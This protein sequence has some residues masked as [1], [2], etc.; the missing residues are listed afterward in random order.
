MIV[1]LLTLLYRGQL[2]L[3]YKELAQSLS[4]SLLRSVSLRTHSFINRFE[5]FV[6]ILH[7][8]TLIHGG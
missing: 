1:S 4:D 2:I 3:F 8:K 5:Y 7:Y 6:P